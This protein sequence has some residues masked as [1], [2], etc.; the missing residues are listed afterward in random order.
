MSVLWDTSNLQPRS[1]IQMAGE[2]I[3]DIFWNAV[4]ARGPKLM[5]REKKFGIWQSWTW[6]QTGTAVRQ[7]TMGLVAS[8]FEVGHC[9]SILSNT[10]LEWVLADM[11]VLSAGGISNG[12]YPT[13]SVA[14][15]QYLCQDSD[16]RVLFVEDEEQLD[17]ALL[18][19]QN[20][21]NLKLIVLLD[22]E[23]LNRFTDPMVVSLEQLSALGEQYDRE[24]P[25][26]FDARRVSRRP[27]VPEV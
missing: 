16:T 20:L 22:T 26:V 21:P 6:Q 17:K 19:R 13:D 25:G 14:Q 2:T 10:R 23:G 5:M 15:V 18:A 11:A 27:V 24:H 7:L 8:G 4:Q 9:A 3:T 1:D 12:I